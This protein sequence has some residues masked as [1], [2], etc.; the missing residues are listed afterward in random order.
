M[1]LVDGFFGF[2]IFWVTPAF[3]AFYFLTVIADMIAG[4]DTVN[5]ATVKA[6]H[7]VLKTEPSDL[8]TID[9]SAYVQ[10]D[11]PEVYRAV[12]LDLDAESGWE[13]L[14]AYEYRS[15]GETHALNAQ[16]LDERDNRLWLR[17]YYALANAA[18]NHIG[19]LEL[20]NG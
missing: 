11:R 7:E 14:C 13:L 8:Q 19:K 6:L 17:G 5:A 10:K 20:G 18:C 9:R 1:R 2:L 16:L 12:S 15:N 3:V 4:P